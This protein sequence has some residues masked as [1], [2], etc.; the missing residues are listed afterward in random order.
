MKLQLPARLEGT[1]HP[2]LGSLLVSTGGFTGDP[3]SRVSDTDTS[4][5][6]RRIDPAKLPNVSRLL[7]QRTLNDL[8]P[9]EDFEQALDMLI[10]GLAA[11]A[12]R[13]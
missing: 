6:L 10:R 2:S 4:A 1:I 9:Q 5:Y 12:D 3:S 11:E 7:R 8:S 13:T